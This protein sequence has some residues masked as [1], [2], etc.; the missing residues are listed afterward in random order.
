MSLYQVQKLLYQLNRDPEVRRRYEADADAVLGGYA[1]TEEER[2]AL[3]SGDIGLLYVMGVNGQI[4]MHYAA[5]LGMPWDDYL[6]AMREGVRR[7]GPVRAGIYALA[8]AG[9]ASR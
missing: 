1:L 2:T 5:L 9:E 8:D 3:R 4:L 6:Q 7:H